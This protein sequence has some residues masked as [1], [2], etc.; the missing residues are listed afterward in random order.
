MASSKN[1]PCRY[2]NKEKTSVFLL[3][4]TFEVMSTVKTPFFNRL[5]FPV[6]D[7]A[8][9]RKYACVRVSV[10]DFVAR[11][12]IPFLFQTNFRCESRLHRNGERQQRRP[13]DNN[14][15]YPATNCNSRTNDGAMVSSNIY[16]L[17]FVICPLWSFV[18]PY[19][20]THQVYIATIYKQ[21]R[22]LPA[23]MSF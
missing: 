19:N 1:F 10:G 15:R 11:F 12:S 16:T 3:F 9:S 2:F 17:V 5:T 23:C 20:Y 6:D 8:F 21:V 18:F 4:I 22:P 13:S 14:H 7:T